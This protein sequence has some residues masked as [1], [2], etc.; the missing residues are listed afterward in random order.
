[1]AGWQ[2]DDRED[3][4]ESERREGQP[5]AQ[6]AISIDHLQVL[7]K[8]QVDTEDR[9]GKVHRIGR[10]SAIAGHQ[11][12][13]ALLPAAHHLLPQLLERP[14]HWRE[15][16]HDLLHVSDRLIEQILHIDDH[17]PI[18][19]RHKAMIIRLPPSQSGTG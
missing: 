16:R 2:Q 1:M 7:G 11:H 17:K 13:P 18:Q 14:T 15:L 8:E 9:R 5:A 6:R 4:A 10:A 3:H 19:Q 12:L